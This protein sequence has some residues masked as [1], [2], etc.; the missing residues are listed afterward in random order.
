ML[1]EKVQAYTSIRLASMQYMAFFAALGRS[2][3][4]VMV[5]E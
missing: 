5:S 1:F 4:N 2:Y 3:G